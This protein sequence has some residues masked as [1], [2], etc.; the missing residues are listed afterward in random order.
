MRVRGVDFV[1]DRT[2]SPGKMGGALEGKKKI[3]EDERWSFAAALF[4]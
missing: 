3:Q 4:F 2:A 1:R